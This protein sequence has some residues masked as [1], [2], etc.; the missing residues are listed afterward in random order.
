[1]FDFKRR[2]TSEHEQT[3]E[4]LSAYLDG[5]LSQAERSR[6]ERHLHDCTDCQ[7]ELRDLKQ[8]VALLHALPAA[9]LPRSFLLPVSAAPARRMQTRWVGYG[10]LRAATAVA[11]VLLVLVVSGD[12]LLRLQSTRLAALPPAGRGGG[13][14][15]AAEATAQPMLAAG[16]PS[17]SV[18]LAPE[19]MPTAPSDASAARST[20]AVALGAPP[21]PSAS[22]PGQSPTGLVDSTASAQAAPGGEAPGGAV[23]PPQ[24]EASAEAPTPQAKSLKDQTVVATSTAPAPDSTPVP[25]ATVG[26]A[27]VPDAE[28]TGEGAPERSDLPVEPSGGWEALAGRLS[29]YLQWLERG[30]AATVALLLGAM[31][32]QRRRAL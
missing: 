26:A 23:P 17:P 28:L 3:R 21:G 25:Q 10:F 15:M 2:T 13:P 5:Q 19:V 20:E 11:S 31:L 9:R 24:A 16:A 32:W 8:T 30:L 14:N 1:M 6:V 27:T 4:D 12:A 7:A 18:E 29:P 22:A